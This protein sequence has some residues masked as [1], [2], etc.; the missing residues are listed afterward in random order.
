MALEPIQQFENLLL[1]AKNVL[2][3]LPQNPDGD[4]ICAGRA[5]YFY[6]KK[7]G[8][9]SLLAFSDEFE[10]EKKFSFLPRPENVTGKITGARD[11][12]LAFNT[13]YNKIINVKTEREEE[14]LRIY[15]TPD[16]GAIDPR[17]FSF[18]PAKYKFDLVVVLGSPDKESLGKLYTENPD[19]FYE[20]PVVNIDNHSTNDNFGQ[21]NILGLNASSVSEI[22]AEILEKLNKFSIEGEISE[23]LLT[24]IMSA[25]ESFQNKKTT[26]KALEISSRLMG[27]GA[28][29]QKIVRYLYKTQPFHLLKLWG[30]VMSRL[31]WD[32]ELK[33]VWAPVELADFVQSRSNPQELPW[34]LE[35]IKDNYSEGEI[36]L[37]FHSELEKV[38]AG[39]VKC[40]NLQKLNKIA[41][42]FGGEM[43]QDIATFKLLDKNIEE[44]EKEILEKIRIANTNQ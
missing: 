26:P 38:I 33:L 5:F 15:I 20:V 44:G 27:K 14:E 40:D 2:I 21:I 23:C 4:A 34:I 31:K 37:V 7:K 11:F 13:R 28:N 30:R 3:F 32:S 19:I 9:E 1:N 18:I 29:Q 25:T 10:N 17:D 6:L 42:L 36:F 41:G 39:V 12:V 22:L 43:K 16:H 35:K 8:V 24:G